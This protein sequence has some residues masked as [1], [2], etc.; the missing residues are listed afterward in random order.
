MGRLTDKKIGVLMGGRSNEREISLR[1]G[2]A[3]LAA[4]TRRGY[5]A[6]AVDPQNPDTGWIDRLRSE[7]IGIA[8][9]ALHGP[10]GE[11]GTIQG[12]LETLRIPY[13][14]SGVLA[15]AAA[16][17]KV[18]TKKLIAFHAVPSPRF[19]IVRRGEA[20]IPEGLSCPVVVKPP[21]EGST[22][23]VTIVRDP[24][25]FAPA[26]ET[27]FRYGDSALVE[28]YIEGRELTVGVLDGKA[29]PVIEMVPKEGFYDY[30][31]KYTSGMTEYL[32]P[33]PIA[34]QVSREVQACAVE[35]HNILGCAGATRVDLRLDPKDRP[36]VLEINTTPG[37]TETS[38][39]PKA[40]AQE[41]IDYDTLVERILRSALE[42]GR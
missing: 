13:T 37:M 24:A 14:G 8:F 36:F 11:D 29:L 2:R 39:L 21:C 9:L 40:A 17:D 7:G 20:E 41:G 18:V 3:V 15:S 12:L 28:E 33:A 34:P 27:A 26:L 5:R 38:L 35:V 23:G 19:R 22:I 31:A 25:A 6:T 10:G 1:S 16:M 42:R 32:L 30:R 4:L